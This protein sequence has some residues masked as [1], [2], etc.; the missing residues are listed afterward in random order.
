TCAL[1]SFDV[2]G[3]TRVLLLIY[4]TIQQALQARTP[5]DVDAYFSQAQYELSETAAAIGLYSQTSSLAVSDEVT[6]IWLEAAQGGPVFH[7]AHFVTPLA[8]QESDDD[9]LNTTI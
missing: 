1:L 3:C 7:Y 9:R 5:D 4:G 6:D 8:E 2:V